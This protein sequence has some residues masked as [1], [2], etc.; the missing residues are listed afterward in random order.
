MNDLP[1]Q[2]D[3]ATDKPSQREGLSV[4]PDEARMRPGQTS[5]PATTVLQ[6][7]GGEDRRAPAGTF[8]EA[9]LAVSRFLKKQPGVRHAGLTR[10]A[11]APAGKGAWEAE[12]EVYVPNWTI[13]TL[14]LRVH[15]QVL[16]RRLYVLRLDS[17]LN[18]VAYELKESAEASE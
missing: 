18:V 9:R 6:A 2:A 15:R 12:A 17:E 4:F 10:L 3:G 13:K 14:G 5:R 7:N 11:Q 8:N 1:A 16:D